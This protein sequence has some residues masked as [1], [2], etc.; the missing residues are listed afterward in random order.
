ME[1]VY[2]YENEA[3]TVVYVGITNNMHRRTHQHKADKLSLIRNPAVFYF[4]VL[5]RPDAEML[6]TYLID[7]YKTG[8]HYNISKTKKGEF[9]FLDICDLLPWQKWDGTQRDDEKP[10]LVS[11]FVD[12]KNTKKVIVEKKVFIE[13]IKLNG[14]NIDK[15]QANMAEI[16]RMNRERLDYE[17]EV[18]DF[19][20]QA[21]KLDPGNDAIE[22]G[23]RL[24]VNTR[25]CFRLLRRLLNKMPFVPKGR[26]QIIM[27]ILTKHENELRIFENR[28]FKE[29]GNT[30]GIQPLI[31]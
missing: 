17:D 6:E 16:S 7:Y 26:M 21:S 10:F 2:K 25:R 29:C 27:A 19:L 24:H 30:D 18:I 12:N 14:T 4:P 28:L 11:S 5:T 8:Q 1:Y 23:L 20:Q 13:P 22:T 9:T 31:Y 3:G 15:Y